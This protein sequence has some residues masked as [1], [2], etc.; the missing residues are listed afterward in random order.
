MKYKYLLY[1]ILFF[2]LSINAQVSV[3]DCNISNIELTQQDWDAD[4]LFY[5]SCYTLGG[6]QNVYIPNDEF[7]TVYASKRITLKKDTHIGKNA[8]LNGRTHLL[9][10]DSSELDVAVM[11]YPDLKNV[12]RYKKLEI[13]IVLPIDIQNRVDN[14]LFN[15]GNDPNELNPFLEWDLDVEI[16]FQKYGGGWYETID[17]F[18]T[19]DY[20]QN[21][22]THDWD[23]Q[24]TAYPFRVRYAPPI[25]GKWEARVNIKVNGQQAYRSHHFLFNVIESG[26]PGYV[27]VHENS[28]NLKRG[29]RMIFPIGQNFPSPGENCI[30]WAGSCYF[31]ISETL[32][33]DSI[34]HINQLDTTYTV[35]TIYYGNNL[36]ADDKTE[37]SANTVAWNSYLKMIEQYL[38]MEDGGSSKYFRTI[39]AP[40]SSLIEFED[41]GNYYK[42]LHYAAETDKILELCEKYD[43][44]FQ[45]NLMIQEPMMKYANYGIWFWDWDHYI[46]D[47][48][49]DKSDP[50]Q[51]WYYNLPIYCYNDDPSYRNDG[52]IYTGS[53]KAYEMFTNESDLA[54]HKQRTRYYI[55]RYGYS[56]K[57][58][59]FEILSEPWHINEGWSS[60]QSNQSE[61]SPF[62]NPNHPDHHLARNAIHNYHKVISEFIKDSLN[63]FNHLIGIDMAAGLGDEQGGFDKS[64]TLASIDIVGFNPYYVN[65]NSLIK[66]MGNKPNTLFHYIQKIRDVRD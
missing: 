25:N 34:M 9:I 33:G 22:V 6:N 66:S 44:L 24:N 58:Y 16:T 26:D 65:P 54:Y 35:D 45:F 27:H 32:Y 23:D 41:K 50:L 8:S 55:A 43:A 28:K 37:K 52:V 21:P 59:E 56:T 18:Y 7:K 47:T 31:Q 40:Y 60:G 62:L 30:A 15:E 5:G 49:P 36:F 38:Q 53:K 17:G 3:Y 20:K 13:G 2:S 48:L 1:S 39:Q 29:E 11:N 46:H 57:I 12:R 51:S 10:T 14:F 63:H 4:S 61:E 19:R 64:I 42:R